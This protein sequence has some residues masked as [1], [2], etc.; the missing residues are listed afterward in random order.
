MHVPPPLLPCSPAPLRPSP[1]AQSDL[2]FPQISSWFPGH[3]AR[4]EAQNTRMLEMQGRVD[5]LLAG[6]WVGG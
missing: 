2:C 6:G 3:T 1:L 4:F 5:K